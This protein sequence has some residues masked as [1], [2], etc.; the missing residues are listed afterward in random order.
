MKKLFTG[1]LISIVVLF[2]SGC[3]KQKKPSKNPNIMYKIKVENRKLKLWKE[4][5]KK[6][7]YKISKSLKNPF[8]IYPLISPAS[9]VAPKVTISIKLVGILQKGGE[10]IALVEDNNNLGY[11]VRAGS[12][13]GQ[14][15]IVKVGK[16]YIVINQKV[17]IGNGKFKI[18]KK[19]LVLHKE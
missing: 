15:K 11:F 8:I 4:E 19:V 6:Q 16:N 7:P 12:Q 3:S 17:N 18:I 10:R 5:L 13:I 14:V 9:F 2:F 1:I